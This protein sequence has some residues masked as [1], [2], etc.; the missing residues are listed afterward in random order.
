MSFISQHMALVGLVI[1]FG[2]LAFAVIKGGPAERGSALI[3]GAFWMFAVLLNKVG[4]DNEFVL[5]ILAADGAIAFGYLYLAVRYS[6]LWIASAMIAQGLAFGM[7]AFALDDQGNVFYWNGG[8]IY[9]MAING[10]SILGLLLIAGGTVNAMLTRRA[11]RMA[12]A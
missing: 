10:L 12:T 1:L 2:V 5:P 6:N 4:D 9:L 3:Y 8:Y 11:G 7:H